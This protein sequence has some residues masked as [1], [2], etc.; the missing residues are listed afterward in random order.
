[1]IKIEFV[2]FWSPLRLQHFCQQALLHYGASHP[3]EVL[4]RA[5]LSDSKKRKQRNFIAPPFGRAKRSEGD[6]APRVNETKKRVNIYSNYLTV[7]VSEPAVV[8]AVAEGRIE[9]EPEPERVG[10][11]KR[12]RD[13]RTR[14]ARSFFSF[15][16]PPLNIEVKLWSRTTLSGAPRCNRRNEL[17]GRRGRGDSV[18]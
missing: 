15:Y 6:T 11:L 2:D 12:S 1:M 16:F 5:L 18:Q 17:S 9:P 4:R 7:S 14:R 13:G 3:S 10:E 8:V